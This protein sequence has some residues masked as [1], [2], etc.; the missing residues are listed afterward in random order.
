MQPLSQAGLKLFY[1]AVRSRV[2]YILVPV[3]THQCKYFT[4]A[5]LAGGDVN[6]KKLIGTHS[7]TFHCD[8]A[9]ACFM[10]RK[11]PE[12]SDAEIVRSR[13]ESVLDTC[14]IVVDVGGEYDP[15]KHRYDHHQRSFTGTMNSLCPDKPWETKLSSAGLVYLH[16]G[17]RVL[18]ELMGKPVDKEKLDAIYDKE[19][20]LKAVELVG[21]EFV[22]RVMYYSNSWWPA[23][24]LVE[25]SMKNRFEVHES[26]EIVI[27]GAGGCPWKEHLYALEKEMGVE[28]PIK[29]VLYTDQ[30]NKWRVQCVSVAPHSFENRLS[31]PEKWRGMRNNELSEIASIPNCIFVHSSGFIGGNET[32]EGALQMAVKALIMNK[33]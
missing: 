14:D 7:G 25:D 16:F 19:R 9:L 1:S 21:T 12:Y 5:D 4:M 22:D 28:T 30:A 31:L 24:E 32:K 26:G 3:V 2:Q 13:D 23:R 29:Y 18:K 11:L 10:L 33:S 8:E 17:E 27:F 6:R 20:F 15:S